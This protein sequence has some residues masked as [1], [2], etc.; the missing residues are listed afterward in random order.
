MAQDAVSPLSFAVAGF[1]DPDGDTVRLS[2]RL[3]DGSTLP[4]WLH[5]DAATAWFDVDGSNAPAGS[6]FVVSPSFA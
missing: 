1:E 5:F 3:L 2:A 6:Y 4:P